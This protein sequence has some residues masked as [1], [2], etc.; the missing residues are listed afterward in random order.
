MASHGTGSDAH[1]CGECPVRQ[2][3]EF[4]ELDEKELAILHRGRVSRS[5]LPGELLFF[6]GGEPEGVYAV[7]DGLV[8]IRKVD[9]AGNSVLLRLVH[10][11][12][13]MGYRAVLSSEAHR[14]S[15]EAIQPTK[16][17]FINK[18]TV[19]QLI[20]ARPAIAMRFISHA[21]R[22]LQA[23]EEKILH[24]ATLSVRE[25][26]LNLLLMLRERY[27]AL[28]EDGRLQVDLPMSRQD[29]AAMIGIRPESMSR[30]I[31]ALEDE[32]VAEF[33]GRTVRLARL[34][35]GAAS[36]SELFFEP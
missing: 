4:S 18:A 26:F 15:G 27:G 9:I 13:T 8:G 17:C 12:E 28:D 34:P 36:G 23:A 6:E 33:S 29:M 14:A 30:I 5:Y 20:E 35:D 10:P 19:M 3:T 32:G 16:V 11:G 1:A 25:R 22:D 7:I 24:G 31:R 21:G 2:L